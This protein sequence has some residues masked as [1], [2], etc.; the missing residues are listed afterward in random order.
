MAE[1]KH[2]IVEILETTVD[3]HADMPA[4]RWMEGKN[5]AE[6]KYGDVN[7][8]RNRVTNALYAKGFEGQHIAMIGGSSYPWIVS[9]LG[10]VGGR[11]TAVPLDPVLPV[12]ELC[13]L[14]NRS[15]SE[16]L[17]LSPKVSG[18]MEEVRRECPQVRL[19]VLLLGVYGYNRPL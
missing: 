3:K 12:V 17:F 7:A 16:A 8:D 5:I 1:N 13:D 10:I 2:I 19:F 4:V 11:M 9:Y 18:I 15:D 14:I 6:K